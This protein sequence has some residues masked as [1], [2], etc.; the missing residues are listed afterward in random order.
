MGWLPGDLITVTY[1]KE[2]LERQPFRV[3][4]L[5]PG[6]NYQTVQVTAQWHDDNWYTTGGAGTA[7]GSPQSGAGVGLP[8]PL[9]G[10][11]LDSHGIEQFGITEADTPTAGGGFAVTLA[12]AF[13]PPVKPQP[14]GA[15]I[16]LVSLS[17]AVSPTGGTIAGGQT[18]YY[19]VSA[20][21]GSGAESGLSFVIMAVIPSGAN[22]NSVS[23]TGFSFSAGTAGF[24]V[25]RGP[26]PYELLEIATNVTVASS[27]TDSG[28]AATLT[29]PPDANYDHANFYWRLELQPEV[30]VN[31]ESA[32]THRQQHAGDADERFPGSAGE[33]H[34]RHGSG[35]GA[36]GAEQQRDDADGDSGVDGGAGF[37]EL[38]RGGASDVEFCGIDGDE[39]GDDRRAVRAGRDGGDFGTVGE[40]AG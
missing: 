25:Y 33:D 8:R 40:C 4:Q 18:L 39:S 5:A 21:D 26:N 16:P 31:L 15:N 7:G 12:V 32:T 2:G 20:L 35:A 23:L 11:V 3:V 13:D 1:L 19:A 36:G 14:S 9:V 24:N 37:D 30:G 22:T 6:Q 28:V 38:L 17:P 10:S 34:A 27:Y 29:G